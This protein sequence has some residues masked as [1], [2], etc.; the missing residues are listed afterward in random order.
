LINKPQTYAS[1]Y[2][3]GDRTLDFVEVYQ[4]LTAMNVPML[5]F[6]KEFERLL[7]IDR[8]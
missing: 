2:E 3:K 8:F 7:E 6:I 4:I 5:G 1:K